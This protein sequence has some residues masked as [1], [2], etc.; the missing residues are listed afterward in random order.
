VSADKQVVLSVSDQTVVVP[1]A[2]R[3][4]IL[5]RTSTPEPLIP[6]SVAGRLGASERGRYAAGP[7]ST[8]V[9][10]LGSGTYPSFSFSLRIGSFSCSLSVRSRS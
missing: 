7:R 4:S 6:F 5:E 3:T 10:Q 1:G 8:I 2:G 9:D